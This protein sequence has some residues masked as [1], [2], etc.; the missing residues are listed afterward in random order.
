MVAAELPDITSLPAIPVLS[1]TRMV[2]NPD[3]IDLLLSSDQVA[4][5]S[6]FGAWSS[7]IMADFE[8]VFAPVFV[9]S[10]TGP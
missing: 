6:P 1:S 9:H 5:I 4:H 10:I 2:W 8:V 3:L 7:A